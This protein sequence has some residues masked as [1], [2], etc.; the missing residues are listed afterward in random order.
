MILLAFIIILLFIAWRRSSAEEQ[1]LPEFVRELSPLVDLPEP[2]RELYPLVK[3]IAAKYGVPSELVLAIITVESGGRAVIT[4]EP[5]V[6][7]FA[8]GPMQVLVSTAR[9]LGFK[10]DAYQLA[11]PEN[12][13]E[14]G[15]RYLRYQLDRYGWNY[16]KAVS[17]YN[18][19]RYTPLNEG[20]VK[21]VMG[22]W[23]QL[24]GFRL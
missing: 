15:V 4:P 1:L 23:Q 3:R 22:I 17:A 9:S 8:C 21:R 10:G 5:K 6:N 14:Y 19:G 12:S 24:R 16:T 2:V 7:D 18:A 20:Y 11:K 13:I